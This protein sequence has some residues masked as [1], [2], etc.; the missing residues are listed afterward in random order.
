MSQAKSVQ[1][2]LSEGNEPAIFVL[3]RCIEAHIAENWQ[4][5]LETRHDRLL[6]TYH[7]LGEMVYG[8]YG[9]FLFRPVRQ[10]LKQ[11]G[12]RMTP[13]LPGEF[14]ISREWGPEEDRQRWMWS[15]VSEA[16]GTAIGTIV[17]KYFH[18]H[19]EFRVPRPPEILALTE[20]GKDA[21]V[22]ALSRHSSDFSQAREASIEIEE[23]LRS[24]ETA[25]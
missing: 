14:N 23:Y 3:G 11:A 19:T 10:Q 7:R 6:D 20:T 2:F 21:V 25:S 9:E 18:D 5:V 24:L 15:T 12:F 16:A 22:A 8:A 4:H 17:V 1:E 13:R